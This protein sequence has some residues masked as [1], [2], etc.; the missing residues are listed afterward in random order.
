MRYRAIIE[1]D[2]T[3]YCGFQRQLTGPSI[4]QE[5]ERALLVIRGKETTVIGAGRTD[6][7]VHAYGQVVAYDLD[8]PHSVEALRRALNANLPAD[9]AVIRLSE[10]KDDFHPRF[11]ALKRSYK[12]YIYNEPIRSPLYRRTSWHISQHLDIVQMNLAAKAIVGEHDFA[13]FG[14]PPQGDN[15]LRRVFQA[16]W[17]RDDSF[18]IFTVEANSFLYRMVR[19]LVGCMKAVGDGSWTSER[20]L[21]ALKACDRNHAAQTAPPH[22]LFLLSVSYE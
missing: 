17:I 16:E 13:T 15:S 22:A 18:L 7:G 12:Y 21:T 1:Y 10:T 2:G 8:W 9:I 5:L 6:S 20:F 11:D 14:R 19:S 4:Q 3:A